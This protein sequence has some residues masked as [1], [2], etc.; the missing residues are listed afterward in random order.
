VKGGFARPVNRLPAPDWTDSPTGAR[1]RMEN[2]TKRYFIR[3]KETRAFV[4]AFADLVTEQDRHTGFS[5]GYNYY[6]VRYTTHTIGGLSENGFTCAAIINKH[7]G[8]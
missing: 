1:V 8:P 7:L 2:R 4:N 5:T 6:D 3:T